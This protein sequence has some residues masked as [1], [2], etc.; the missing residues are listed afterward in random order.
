MEMFDSDSYLDTS[1]LCTSEAYMAAAGENKKTT[2]I[3]HSLQTLF[4]NTTTTASCAVS[5]FSTATAQE[6]STVVTVIPK[7][8]DDDDDDAKT[9]ESTT[10]KRELHS[11]SLDI[12]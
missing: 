7:D 12:L 3:Q 1:N 11:L 9:D 4:Q 10:R 5:S 2:S 8:D 6:K